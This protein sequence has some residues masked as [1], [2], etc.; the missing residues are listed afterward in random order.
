MK[1]TV[2]DNQ[3]QQE[4]EI[5]FPVLM[6]HVRTKDHI[7]MFL[8]ENTGVIV[9]K[10]GSLFDVGGYS[11]TYIEFNNRNYWKPLPNGVKITLENDL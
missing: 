4:K 1:V 5:K 10:G 9:N 11:E 6:K 7:V 2:I 3:S 8:N